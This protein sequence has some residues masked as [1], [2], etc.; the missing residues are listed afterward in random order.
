MIE[1]PFFFFI[2]KHTIKTPDG[3]IIGFIK[4]KFTAFKTVFKIYD[5]SDRLIFSV[6]ATPLHI[7][8]YRIYS[9]GREV[10]KIL[11]KWGSLVKEMYSDADSFMVDFG[12][13]SDETQKKLILA[14]AFAIDLRKFEGN[15]KPGVSGGGLT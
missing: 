4:Q 5:S 7:W 2:P 6:I 10:G 9:E 11:K 3:R 13:I 14:C 15:V 12:T 8:T 1:R